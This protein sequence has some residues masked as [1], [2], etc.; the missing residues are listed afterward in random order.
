MRIDQFLMN[1]ND[2][3]K[4]CLKQEQ[5]PFYSEFLF[6]FTENQLEELWGVVMESH[7]RMSPP[8][9]G[10]LKKFSKDI[11]LVKVVS[12]YDIKQ[13]QIKQLTD[14]E[15]FNSEMGQLGLKEGWAD[16]YRI[17]CKESG[18]PSYDYGLHLEFQKGQEA[19]KSAYQEMK[20]DIDVFSVALKGLRHSMLRKNKDW[21]EKYNHL[22]TKSLTHIEEIT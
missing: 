4:P 2:L 14:E 20:E 7:M 3:Y 1:L 10:E 6:K 19:A 11:K 16:T 15:I 12:D 8:T 9:I 13:Q 17:Y 22:T 18:I 5:Q 21:Q